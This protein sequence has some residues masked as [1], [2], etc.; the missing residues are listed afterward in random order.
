MERLAATPQLRATI[1]RSIP[2]RR[3]GTM[4]SPRWRYPSRSDAAGYVSGAIFNCAGA[5]MLA[6]GSATNPENLC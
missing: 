6:G 2:L 3:Y 1:E 4:R 5:Q